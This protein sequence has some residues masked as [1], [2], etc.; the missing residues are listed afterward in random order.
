MT[1][2]RFTAL[3][4][5]AAALAACGK[6]TNRDST[7]VAGDSLTAA[8]AGSLE[9]PS[10]LGRMMDSASMPGMDRMT[11]SRMT[12]SIQ[13]H[14]RGMEGMSPDQTKAM[15]PMHR[16]MVANMLSMFDDSMRTMNMP[17][18]AAWIALRDSIRQDLVSMP[19]LSASQLKVLMRQHQARVMRLMKMHQNMTDN[20]TK[21]Q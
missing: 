21:P 5:S 19:E 9:A 7:T 6:S 4:L 2:Y 10:R 13:A 3:T 12:D 14:M 18:D 1:A 8:S 17:S 16:Q 20:M 11:G 15:V